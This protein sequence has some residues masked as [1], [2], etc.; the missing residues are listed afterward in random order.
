MTTRFCLNIALVTLVVAVSAC[1]RGPEPAQNA[2]AETVLRRGNG[3]EP[4]TLDPTRADDAHAFNVL[5]DLYEGLVT[6]AADGSLQPGA[7]ASWQHDKTRRRFE[8]TLREDARWS[9]GEPVTADD[10]ARGLRRLADPAT[11]APFASLLAA[12]SGFDAVQAGDA[13]PSALGV[14]ARDART[15]VIALDAPGHTLLDT[16]ALPVAAPMHASMADGTGFADPER[17]VGNGPYRL[18]S[19]RTNDRIRIE[20]NPYHRDAS[21]LGYCHIEFLPVVNPATEVTMYR[22]GELDLTQTLPPQQVAT[23]RERMPDAVR[24]APQL[25]VYFMAFDTTEPALASRDLRRA[26]SLAIDRPALTRMLGRGEQPAWQLLPPGLLAST[27]TNDPAQLSDDARR[28]QAREALRQALGDAPAPTL[29]LVFDA[30]DVHERIAL[31]VADMWRDVLGIETALDKRE[32]AYFLETRGNRA[33][34]D[35][36][37]YA[38]FADYPD[39]ASFLSMFETGSEHNLPG[40]ELPAYDEALSNARMAANDTAR[41]QALRTAAQAFD[42]AYA[43]APLYYFVSKRLVRPGLS[44]YEDNLLDRHPSRYLTPAGAAPAGCPAAD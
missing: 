21:R 4:G 25:G 17:F 13:P 10:F 42:A 7:A 28:T 40:F 6:R 27:A 37:R 38:W 12:V 43:V 35:V 31:A 39:A 44:G 36:M 1:G 26:L 16:L 41:E 34:W 32:W 3:G 15:L 2:D 19:Y 18:A 11:N 22:A 20:A 9:T 24:I 29:R 5:G 8:F 14:M 30:G 23:L 33:D